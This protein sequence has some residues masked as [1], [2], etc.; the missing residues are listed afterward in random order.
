MTVIPTPTADPIYEAIKAEIVSGDLAP[1]T[2]LRQDEIA[3]RHGVSKVPVREA[4]L[5]LEADGFV[6]F[7]K[8]KG[9]SV[10][11]L[12][13]AELLQSMDIRTAL[14]CKALEL[15]IP[16]MVAADFGAAR[17]VLDAYESE[18]RPERWSSLNVE[19][20][21]ILY[22]PCGNPQLLR[23][24]SD[25]RQRVGPVMRLLVTEVTRLERPAREHRAILEACESGETD[26]A[27]NLLN[28]HIDTSKK[29]T[30]AALRTL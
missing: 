5:R 19:F 23:M 21:D 11:G 14:E 12:T 13:T 6:R 30:A 29:E 18:T 2:P 15:A 26:R 8:N 24:I 22:R 20:H 16:N 28:R 17:R 10:R 25:L 7:Q 27:V 4:L 1:E 3:A 9:A